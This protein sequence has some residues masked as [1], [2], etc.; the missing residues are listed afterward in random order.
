MLEP[1]Q[2][3]TSDLSEILRTKYN[4]KKDH[5]ATIAKMFYKT[6]LFANFAINIKTSICEKKETSNHVHVVLLIFAEIIYLFF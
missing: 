5:F 2:R 1:C 4:K 3:T 6:Y